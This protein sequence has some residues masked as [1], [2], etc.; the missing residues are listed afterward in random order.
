MAL[1]EATTRDPVRD[2]LRLFIKGDEELTEHLLKVCYSAETNNPLNLVVIAPTSEG[3]TWAIVHV[4]E[5]FPNALAFTDASAKSFFYDN[6]EL[7]DKDGNL[8][9]ERVDELRELLSDSRASRE[10]KVESR[11][12]LRGLLASSMTRV[13]FDGRILVFLD[14]PRRDLWAALK[15]LLSHDK[16]QMV[17]QSVDKPSQGSARV[18]K[19]LLEGWPASI[20]AT[21]RDED[22]WQGWPEIKSRIIE[23]SPRMD[24]AKYAEANKLTSALM[25][26]PSIVLKKRFPESAEKQA[27]EDVA[28]VRQQIQRI[29]LLGHSEGYTERDNFTFNA[30]AEWLE[31]VFPHEAGMRLRQFKVLL[32]YV[33]LSAYENAEMRPKLIVDGHARAILPTWEDVTIS[34]KLILGSVIGSLPEYKVKFWRQYVV[35][36]YEAK[37]RGLLPMEMREGKLVPV[38]RPPDYAKAELT[39]REILDYAASK[40]YTMGPSRLNDTFLK[41]L[42]ETG[43]VKDKDDSEDRRRKL[44]TPVREVGE[45]VERLRDLA[46][47]AFDKPETVQRALEQLQSMASPTIIN[48]QLFDSVRRE[49]QLATNLSDV[50]IMLCNGTPNQPQLEKETSEMTH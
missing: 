13:K 25:G 32:S 40:G 31:S 11:A 12:E 36:A 3:K 27:K 19:V 47:P 35:G 7:V 44:Y 50:A 26:Q 15:P 5:L 43:Y 9:Q 37:A 34:L 29:R 49:T 24:P 14:A 4:T 30:F 1:A 42:V 17:Y 22:Q 48:Y 33:N 16:R 38:E 39:S 6:G 8:I 20:F 18:K 10:E 45:T 41:S 21:A 2:Y 46:V 28:R 23:V